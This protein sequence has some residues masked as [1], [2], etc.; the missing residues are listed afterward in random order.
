MFWTSLTKEVCLVLLKI[1][2]NDTHTV[3][4]P[5]VL[6]KIGKSK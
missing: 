5:Y 1:I 3:L 2:N 6:N 4:I